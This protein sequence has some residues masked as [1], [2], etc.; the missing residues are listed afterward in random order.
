MLSLLLVMA[1]AFASMSIMSRKTASNNADLTLARILAQS[2]VQRAL[3]AMRFYRETGGSQYDNIISHD[4]S[5]GVNQKTY[6]WLYNLDTVIDGAS[7]Y[8][9]PV[10]YDPNANDAIH[11]QY[12]DNGRTG[13]DQR[14]VG[15]MGLQGL[16]KRL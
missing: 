3:G 12:I 6:D 4:A 1:M 11:W 14:L 5:G 8:P 9:W 15:R 13:A 2:T 10:P 7:I 16:W